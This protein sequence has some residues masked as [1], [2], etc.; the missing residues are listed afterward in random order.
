[1]KETGKAPKF[2]SYSISEEEEST[3]V[4]FMFSKIS[5]L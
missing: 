5:H 4:F 1:M 3:L 2:L